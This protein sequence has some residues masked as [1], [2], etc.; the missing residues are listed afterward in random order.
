MTSVSSVVMTSV[1]SV[2][3]VSVEHRGE[4]IQKAELS[5]RSLGSTTRPIVTIRLFVTPPWSFVTSGVLLASTVMQSHHWYPV[6][7]RSPDFVPLSLGF[8]GG[9]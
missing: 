6:C 3:V 2:V 4:Y 7:S 8:V 9:L 5:L 1:V